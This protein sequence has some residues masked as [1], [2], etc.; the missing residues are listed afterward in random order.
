MTKSSGRILWIT[1][2][3]LFCAA[4]TGF[5][6]GQPEPGGTEPVTLKLGN[7]DQNSLDYFTEIVPIV[8]AYQEVK[9]N[10][11]IE[12]EHFSSTEEY[13]N[14]MKIRL[15]ADELPDVFPL[16]PYMLVTFKDAVI[17]LSELDACQNNKFASDMAVQGKVVG[18]PLTSF[19][20][21]VYYRKS[22]FEELGLSIPQ[23][24][25]E[26]VQL[27]VDIKNNSDYIPLLIGAKDAWPDY[28]FNEFMPLLEAGNGDYWNE[29]AQ[30][31][32]PFSPGRPFYEAYKKIDKLYSADVLGDSPL[33]I[34]W[35]QQRQ[36][37][38]ADKAVMTALGQWFVPT[39]DTD[40][41]DLSDLGTFFLPVRDSKS[42]PMVVTTMADVFYAISESSPNKEEAI[43]FLEW[44]F[45]DYY[46]DFIAWLR[47]G[48]TMEGIEAE[49][50][51]LQ[52]AFDSIEGDYIMTVITPDGEEFTRI[53]GEVQLDVKRLGQEMMAGADLDQMM[54]D[55][56]TKWK[57]A[58]NK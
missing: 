29:M 30:E 25:D 4:L 1:A 18:I 42:E 17:D 11:T 9:P 22:M 49:D 28:P 51:Y 34:G 52:E 10:V 39:F 26:F 35:E 50:P 44:F 5:S 16:K 58:F 7:W 48:P 8:E 13:E 27:A 3:I 47:Q 55:L 40:G 41:G 2:L 14:A 15:S 32:Q 33:S 19:Y 38:A 23:T 46:V 20:E 57:D 36:I 37:Y 31:E 56:N 21:F 43:E 12:L 54:Q 45:T 53:K 6:I 24:W